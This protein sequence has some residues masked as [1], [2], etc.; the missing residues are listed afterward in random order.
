MLVGGVLAAVVAGEARATDPAPARSEDDRFLDGLVGDWEV[1][2][3]VGRRPAHYRASGHRLLNGAW[4]AFHMTDIARPPGYEAT[5]F[6]AADDAAHDYVA[7]WL[8]RFGGGGARV[9]ASGTRSGDTL[10]LTFP[11]A[12][13]SFR[14]FW[15]RLPDG[16]WTLAID[17][18]GHDGSWS[19][20]AQYQIR[21]A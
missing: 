5:V 7:H 14:N 17:A 8:D 21:L 3:D 15:R 18:Q 6:I 16:S 20:F 4:L 12:D 9:A 11:Y 1:T 13:G 19:H 10:Q 2:G